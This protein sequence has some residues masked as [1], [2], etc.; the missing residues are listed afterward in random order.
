[1]TSKK[2]LTEAL[3]KHPTKKADLELMLSCAELNFSA[4]LLAAYRSGFIQR[5]NGT[6][7]T[8]E[9]LSGPYRAEQHRRAYQYG[10]FGADDVLKVEAKPQAASAPAADEFPPG[11]QTHVL[12]T[13]PRFYKAMETG[14]KTAELRFDDRGFN[15]GDHLNLVEY[16]PETGQLTGAGHYQE[17]TH[18]FRGGG[19]GLLDGYALLSLKRLPF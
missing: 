8:A 3:D 7:N 5:L 13:W 6:G 11:W 1:M 9:L 16:D 12:K 4:L 18:I 2:Q 17:V 15:V 10:Y 19:F 14:E